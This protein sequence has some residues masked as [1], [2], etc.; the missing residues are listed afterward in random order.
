M[1]ELFRGTQQHLLELTLW[2]RL[3]KVF[4]KMVI[5]LA[6]IFN[7]DVGEIIE[8]LMQSDQTSRQL[9]AILKV[10]VEFEDNNQNDD[11]T[12]AWLAVA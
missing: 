11:K 7:V 8:K 1:G 3:V 10:V 6:M 4:L 12:T 9:L 2:E 5:Q